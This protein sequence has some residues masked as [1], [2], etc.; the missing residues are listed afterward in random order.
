MKAFFKKHNTLRNQIFSLFS[1]VS[2]LTLT[3]ITAL[4]YNK[5]SS[6]YEDVMQSQLEQTSI[7]VKGSIEAKYD[8]V[9]TIASQLA[10]D[11]DIQKLMTDLQ[12]K[13]YATLPQRL[14]FKQVLNRYYPYVDSVFDY[15][16]YTLTGEPLF[17]NTSP[18]ESIIPNDWTQK[19]LDSQGKLIWVGQDTNSERY[20]YAIKVVRLM[21]HSFVNSGFLV[22]KLENEYFNTQFENKKNFIQVYDS[23]QQFITGK[24]SPNLFQ[25][26]H[27][28]AVLDDELFHIAKSK[29][30]DTEWTVFV[31]QSLTEY[32]DKILKIRYFMIIIAAI[33]ACILFG[34]S[35][36]IASSITSPLKRLTAAMRNDKKSIPVPITESTSSI[37]MQTLHQTYNQF[38]THIEELL[39]EV[40]E[41]QQLQK[42][43][44]MKAWQ[45][46]INPH[47]LYNT[48]NTFYW[49][50]I[51]DDHD[52]LA[53]YVIAMSALF[54][55]SVNASNTSDIVPIEQELAHITHYLTL[56]K[57]RMGERLEWTIDCEPTLQQ[58]MIPKLLLQPLVENAIVHGIEP[59]RSNGL[60]HLTLH[61]IDDKRFKIT[62][63]DNGIGMPADTLEKLNLNSDIPE[64][65]NHIGIYN[66]RMRISTHYSELV[67]D[68][69]HFS[70]TAEKGTTV[71]MIL[72]KEENA[73]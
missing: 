30:Q 23:S 31:A 8:Q 5:F 43:A 3:T 63:A 55:Y 24:K 73:I 52:E 56:M 64:S 14:A 58:R 36:F 42:Q 48:L 25:L 26:N 34:L 54:K 50:L 10:T 47:F 51:E 38:I 18:L 37:E 29:S 53:N 21:N 11:Q 61:S 19:A 57:M 71:T 16:F 49:K 39:N 67:A 46:Q 20:S 62:I 70:S 15:R 68:S 66:I 27:Q 17:P 32:N 65:N 33:S 44:E 35:W 1:I 45:S 12:F 4:G 60:I 9:S 13:T 2:L 69:L 7:E 72:P 28:K 41:K 40:Y 22:L 6:V 59:Q